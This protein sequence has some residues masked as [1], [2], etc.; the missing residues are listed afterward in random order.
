MPRHPPCALHSL[1][2]TPPTQPTHTTHHPAPRQNPHT[3][4]TTR[5]PKGPD[6]QQHA[7]AT[8]ERHSQQRAHQA[9]DAHSTQLQ[10]NLMLASTIQI[11]NNNPTPTQTHHHGRPTQAGNQATTPHHPPPITGQGTD[12]G[13]IPQNPNS[14]PPPTRPAGISHLGETRT[15]PAYR[16]GRCR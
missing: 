1:S 15:D 4:P 8:K 9:G 2:H 10:K 11:S 16:V 13:L 6:H 14:V 7:G 5:P 12:T 3:P